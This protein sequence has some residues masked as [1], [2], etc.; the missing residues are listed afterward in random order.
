V[1]VKRKAAQS[2]RED[3]LDVLAELAGAEEAG[4]LAD[5]TG[6]SQPDDEL[7]RSAK[8]LTAL[9]T[10][11]LERAQPDAAAAGLVGESHL[12]RALLDRVKKA[13]ADLALAGSAKTVSGGALAN[14][15]PPVNLAEGRVL[16]ELR[17]ALKAFEKA[18]EKD[19][20]VPRI[21]PGAGTRRVLSPRPKK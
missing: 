1:A 7:A 8:A 20:E 19:P 3:L 4:A 14:D 9:G 21:V 11:W 12:D 2:A 13:A 17:V 16:A 10:N 18:H 6:A 5:A 15:T